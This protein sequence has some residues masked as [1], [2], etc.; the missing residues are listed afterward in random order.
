MADLVKLVQAVRDDLKE[1]YLSDRDAVWSNPFI[2]LIRH[3]EVTVLT[4]ANSQ[5]ELARSLNEYS[6]SGGIE[7]I[8]VGRMVAKYNRDI[9]G[10]DGSPL[11]T[12]KGVMVCG[13]ILGTRQTYITITRCLEHRDLR[14]PVHGEPA[15]GRPEIPGLSSPD[16]VDP[17]F[18]EYGDVRGF[19][20]SQFGVERVFDSRRGD[21]CMLDPIIQGMVNGG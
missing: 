11:M 21:I 7:G 4:E 20:E 8:V 15:P 9:S 13:R 12:E 2:A 6:A 10:P 1:C 17:I 18:T 19:V 3:G 16:K 14:N 5:E